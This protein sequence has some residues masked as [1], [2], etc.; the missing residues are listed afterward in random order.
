MCIIYLRASFFTNLLDPSQLLKENLVNFHI[1]GI[2]I[3]LA[4]VSFDDPS[5]HVFTS[6]G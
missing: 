1:N 5:F 2:I 6:G 3:Q 4:L